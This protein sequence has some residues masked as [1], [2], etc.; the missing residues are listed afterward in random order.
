[1]SLRKG[2]VIFILLAFGANAIILSKSVT[3]ETITSLLG[4]DKTFLLA[5]LGLTLAAWCCDAGRFC[6]LVR[7]AHE[8]VSFKWG[9]AL[10]WLHYFGC[11][12][13]PMQSGGGPFQVYVLYKKGIPIGKGIAITLIRTMLTV[14]ILSFVVPAAFFIDPDLMDSSPFIRGVVTYVFAVIFC[15]WLLIAYTILRPRSVKRVG[16]VFLLWLRKLKILPPDKVKGYIQWLDREMDNY[17]LNFR[18][19]FSSGFGYSIA[20]VLLSVLHLLCV[21]SVLPVL[22]YSVG[23]P[24]N[25]A[26]TLATQ[27]I[28]MFVLYFIPTP[29]A[30]G[31]A[32]SGGAILFGTLMPW[33]MAGIMSIIWRFFTEYISIFMGVITAVRLVGWGVTEDLHKGASPEEEV[34]LKG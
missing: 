31:V 27:A 5:A 3:S 18:L 33:N 13:T 17:N 26:Q 1:M 14:L 30:S 22:M 8:N 11:A 19:A 6:A 20:A 28:F 23:L 34:K 10:T 16:K 25:F 32:E 21:F 7:A 24:F 9:I 4:A 29:G 12:V 15:T 2:L